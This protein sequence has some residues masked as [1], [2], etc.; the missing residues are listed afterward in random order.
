MGVER[1]AGRCGS[2]GDGEQAE[3]GQESGNG[4]D[5]FPFCSD[6]SVAPRVISTSVKILPRVSVSCLEAVS[7]AGCAGSEA[8]RLEP[9]PKGGANLIVLQ[10]EVDG[11]LQ[12][13]KLVA[14]VVTL[15]GILEAKDLLMPQ[16][17]LDG[18]GEL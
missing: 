9:L 12:K 4:F 18:V 8:L 3:C 17:R 13:T 15:P 11:G 7:L 10:R 6:G 14:G 16:Q 1:V 5:G 2:G